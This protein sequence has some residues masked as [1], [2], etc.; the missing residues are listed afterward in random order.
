[1]SDPARLILLCGLS[2][3]GKST[4]AKILAQRLDAAV[5]SLDDINEE[6]GLFGGQGISGEEW[7]ATHRIADE[8]VA[9]L[10]RAGRT[11]IVDDTGS[12]RFVRDRWRSIADQ[13]RAA[14]AI[15]W[16]D[17]DVE[18]QQERW[19]ANRASH[20]RHDVTDE[21]M[22]EHR[23]TFEPPLDENHIRIDARDVLDRTEVLRV[24]S[25]FTT[26]SRPESPDG[27]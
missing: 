6:R 20:V 19:K 9:G 7:E 10:L 21:V 14:F 4:L 13:T 16:V 23:A 5:V 15:V 25:E 1:M 11:V 3:S 18:T 2:F 27:R 26:M 8:R 17:V 22:Q 24:T 12:P